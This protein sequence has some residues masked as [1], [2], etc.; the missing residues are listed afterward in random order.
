MDEKLHRK[1]H[2]E[3]YKKNPKVF[4]KDFGKHMEK[5][6]GRDDG[7]R[8]AKFEERKIRMT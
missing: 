8:K 1:A 4:N 7:L 3:S 5:V 6:K 2:A